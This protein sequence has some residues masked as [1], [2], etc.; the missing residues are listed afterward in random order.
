MPKNG[1]AGDAWLT[2]GAL[3][4]VAEQMFALP[5]DSFLVE[6]DDKQRDGDYSALR[7]VP[8]GPIV[9]LGIVSTKRSQVESED[10]LLRE[11][12]GRPD[13]ST[14][15]SWRYRRSAGSERLRSG[16]ASTRRRSCASWSSRD[17]DRPRL[18]PA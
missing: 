14:S 3:D 12:E 2:S 18:L 4:P 10:D 6:W 16:R 17:A 5:Y 11:I 9:G 13:I 7:H 15:V 1:N 8:K